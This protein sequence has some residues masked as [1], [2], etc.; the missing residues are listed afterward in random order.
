MK[1]VGIGTDIV[2]I[3]RIERLWNEHG[4][5]F[6]RRI[7]SVSELLDLEKSKNKIAFLAKR[8]AAKEA[9]A[10]A[11]GTGFQPNGLL[12]T[13]I[14]VRNDELGRPYLEFLGQSKKETEKYHVTESHLSLSDEKEF[15]V[16]FV[17]LL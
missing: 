5:N 12:L 1:I 7:L 17:I 6:A 14:S 8:Y 4:Q 3:E 13:E 15:A 16:A 11:L 10:K 2:S 9:L